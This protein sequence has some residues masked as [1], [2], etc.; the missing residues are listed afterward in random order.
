VYEHAGCLGASSGFEFVGPFW[1]GAS[2]ACRA[3]GIRIHHHPVAVA[4][5]L[6]GRQ[7]QHAESEWQQLVQTEG[8]DR[9]LSARF[10]SGLKLAI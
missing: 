10:M 5:G 8:V 6:Q 7:I 2:I 9:L 4:V 1:F 3:W